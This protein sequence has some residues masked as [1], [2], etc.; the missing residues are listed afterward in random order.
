MFRYA[1]PDSAPSIRPRE[2]TTFR[3]AWW[4]P[5]PHLPT[6]WGK[7]ARRLTTIAERWLTPDDDWVAVHRVAAPPGAPRVLILHGLEGSARSHY[8]MG[9]LAEARRR[10]WG[11]AVL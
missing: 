4:L 1:G 5:G 8:A 9:M 6:L 10:G 2:L 3:P 7:L 11:A